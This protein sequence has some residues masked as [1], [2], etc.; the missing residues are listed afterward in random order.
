MLTLM[1]RPEADTWILETLHH[2]AARS[3]FETTH[4]ELKR[5]VVPAKE[6][7][8][9]FAGLANA[10]RWSPVL[11]IFGA[12]RK[13]ICGIAP[14]EVGDWYAELRSQFEYGHAPG[15]LYQNFL[16]FQGHTVG[17]FVFDSSNP[18]YVIGQGK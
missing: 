16:L 17:T 12:D 10:A 13:G 8:R 2:I 11:V 9:Q 7:S 6:F 18:P 15:L 1:R 3:P 4:V 5:Q 14:F